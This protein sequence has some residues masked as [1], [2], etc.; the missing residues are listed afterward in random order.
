MEYLDSSV[1][2]LVFCILLVGT[3]CAIWVITK[4]F[5]KIIYKLFTIATVMAMLG[6]LVFEII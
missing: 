6:Y 4:V 2:N 3:L 5:R 1:L